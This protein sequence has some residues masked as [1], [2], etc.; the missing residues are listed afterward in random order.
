MQQ[1]PP[2]GNKPPPPAPMGSTPKEPKGR[3]WQWTLFHP[4]LPWGA[5]RWLFGSYKPRTILI[6]SDAPTLPRLVGRL[7][8]LIPVAE[9]LMSAKTLLSVGSLV[10]IYQ[11][12]AAG[13][14]AFFSQLWI[15]TGATVF[16][17]TPLVAI[18]IV[19]TLLAV[20]KGQRRVAAREMSTAI[21]VTLVALF[22][23]LYGA[24]HNVP[25][26]PK[27]LTLSYLDPYF[28]PDLNDLGWTDLLV[29]LVLL[30]FFFLWAVPFGISSAYLI[31]NNSFGLEGGTLLSPV[32]SIAVA[33]SV[34]IFGPVV[35][36]VE[37]RWIG[38]EATLIG[39]GSAVVVT[40]LSIFEYQALRA[41]GIT[42]KNGPW[43]T[44]A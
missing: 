23:V 5:A 14:S 22:L 28:A 1:P 15:V 21:R 41:R 7:G 4:A 30:A 36:S 37:N 39:L 33:W 13:P 24:G 40:F 18:A 43:G 31:H 35:S 32:V 44:R 8:T 20:E 29:M 11:L 38:I 19:G 9:K 10:L 2:P 25:L 6:A 27:I 16:L 34:A 26:W 3:R 42:L 12:I 17:G